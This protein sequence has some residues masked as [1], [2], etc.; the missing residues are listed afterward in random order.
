MQHLPIMQE[1]Q[2]N[3]L[4]KVIDQS[5]HSVVITD[6]KGIIV[7]VNQ[8][9]CEISGYTS[10]EAIGQNPRILKSGTQGTEVYR[11]L[12]STIKADNVWS[13]QLCNRHKSGSLYW[14]DATIYPVHDGAVYYIAIKKDI[15]EQVL[16]QTKLEETQHTLQN[17]I[18]AVTES[19]CMINR[20]L[21]LVAAN[22]TIAA[23]FNMSVEGFCETPFQ[24]IVPRKIFEHRKRLA[25]QVFETGKSIIDK[26]YRDGHYV[27]TLY[28]PVF[29]KDNRVENLAIFSRDITSEVEA[30]RELQESEELHRIILSNISDALFITDANGDFTYIYPSIEN[31][32]GI[33]EQAAW[34]LKSITKLLP[35][36]SYSDDELIEQGEISNIETE[37]IDSDSQS[38]ILLVTIKSVDIRGGS[39]LYTCRDI[40]DRRKVEDDLR[41]HAMLLSNVSD[42]VLLTDLNF[43]VYSL[44]YAAEAIYECRNEEAIGRNLN[45]LSSTS[46][47]NVTRE[48]AVQTV[49]EQGYWSGEIT[50]VLSNGKTIHTISTF[51]LV[52]DS[53]N[54]PIGIVGIKRDITERVQA[55]SALRSSQAR[56]ANTIELAPFPTMLHSQDGEVIMINNAWSTL[57]GYS[58]QDIPTISMWVDR[59]YQLEQDDSKKLVAKISAIRTNIKLG[60]LEIT[61]AD[62]SKRLWDFYSAPLEKVEG[63]S[64]IIMSVAID[65]TE[66]TIL[67][68]QA[69]QAHALE[70]KLQ[71]ER[72][73]SDLKERLMSTIS[74]EF[75]TPLTVI[76]TSADLLDNYFDRLDEEQRRK[77]LTRISEQIKNATNLLDETMQLRYAKSGRIEF[78]PAPIDIEMFSLTIFDKMRFT[79]NHLHN[80]QFDCQ[81][82]VIEVSVDAKLI[83]HIITNLLSNAIKYTPAGKS[84][85]MILR[86]N[87]SMIYIDI[88]DKGIGIPAEDIPHLFEPYHRATN[89]GSVQGTGLGLAIVKEYID[90]H[91]GQVTCTSTV[92]K[93][94][95]FTVAL[96]IL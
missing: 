61:T 34:A 73:L 92:E 15:T 78:A 94:S 30:R 53:K 52:Y 45:E 77:H 46:Y 82:S 47:L 6:S 50:H 8:F 18:D 2:N 90:L 66:Q 25:H 44:N 9:F 29:E 88:I 91:H 86:N 26:D 71:K 79:D 49:L 96:P 31:S 93:G 54:E 63:K 19:L 22:K 41:Y 80:M 55:E 10:D 27:E 95:T 5:Q 21:K 35:N 72:E 24:D 87:E 36:L 70:I 40:T 48:L 3:M 37:I 67:Q 33:N 38:R 20:D 64:Q 57:S 13:G 76:Q 65:V 1:L 83:E 51:S 81:A 89:V 43:N 68:E 58:H 59:A 56:L 23:R 7:Y 60:I 42:A 11:D 75:R 62:G 84:I 14:E 69:N 85:T 17:M 74:H 28:Y 12:W 39:R 32:F 4:W 16:S